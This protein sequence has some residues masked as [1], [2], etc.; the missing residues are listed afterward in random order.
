MIKIL[1]KKISL[2]FGSL[3]LLFVGLVVLYD[4]IPK[5]TLADFKEQKSK[6]KSIECKNSFKSYEITKDNYYIKDNNIMM[7]NDYLDTKFNI[8]DCKLI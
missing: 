1:M 3:A 8:Y 4:N 2:M 6:G 7:K 5:Q